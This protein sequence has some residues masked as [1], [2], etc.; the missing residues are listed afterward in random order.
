[1]GKNRL[2]R[3]SQIEW[4]NDQ[5]TERTVSSK[6]GEGSIVYREFGL[7]GPKRLEI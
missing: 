4:P 5:T 1:M 3:I 6:E 7:R 2:H